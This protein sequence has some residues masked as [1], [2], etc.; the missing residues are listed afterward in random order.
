MG[1]WNATCAVSHLPIYAGDKVAV[2]P[3]V[4]T[5]PKA[6]YNCCYTTDNF[7]PLSFPIIGEYDEYGGIENIITSYENAQHLKSF[8][9]YYKTHDGKFKKHEKYDRFEEFVSSVLCCHED[10]YI[11]LN[12]KLLFKEGYAEI[13]F[14]MVHYDLYEL[15]IKEIG[16]RIPYGHKENFKNFLFN[17]FSDILKNQKEHLLTYERLKYEEGIDKEKVEALYSLGRHTIIKELSHKI[18]CFGQVINN[19]FWDYFS[20]LLLTDEENTDKIISFAV[21]KTLFTK[22]LSFG[23][24]GYLCSSGC[25]SQSEETKIQY[26]IAKYT[27]NHIRNIAK[28]RNQ[29]DIDEQYDPNGTA[30]QLYC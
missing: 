30:E 12:N 20:E 7:T 10:N 1:C 28:I 17:S 14:M 15:L 8:K 3:L 6:V 16:N 25:G 24:N 27:I 2:I 23:R 26:L 5:L 22:A 13:N 11:K 4:K 19:E 9:Y 29:Y 18:F 21:N